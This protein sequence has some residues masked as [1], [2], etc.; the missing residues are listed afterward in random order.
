MVLAS[1]IGLQVAILSDSFP[2]F[3]AHMNSPA[4]NLSLAVDDPRFR[5]Q[6]DLPKPDFLLVGGAKCGTTSFAAYLPSHPQVLPWMVKEPNFWS[7]RKPSA[8]QYQSLFC[9]VSPDGKPGPQGAVGGDYSTSSLL[10]PL[11]GRRLV[12][13][14][15]RLKIIVML[16]NPIDRAYSHFI[17][18][19]RSGLEKEQS[20]EDIVQVEMAE[21]PALL[22]AHARGFEHPSGALEHCCQD[23]SGQTL[24]FS[25]HN[26]N[27]TQRPLRADVDL[28]AFYYT[29]YVF[30]SIYCDQLERWLSLYPREQIMIMQSEAFFRDPARHMAQAAEFLGLQPHDFSSDSELKRKYAGSVA[31]DW[32]PPEKY[33]PMPGKTRKALRAFFA[34]Y[35]QKLYDLVG[36]DYG[37]K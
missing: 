10:H 28:Q 9:N 16:R 33:P 23:S 7:W 15:P 6:Q 26:R 25:L 22:Q 21:S 11:V 37:W 12:G 4:V 17:M 31:G 32:A 3:A 36:Q 20:F 30:R 1:L 14:L 13:Q 35:N 5:L 24:N 34:P 8:S 18:S 2:V 19:Q 27:W 29:S